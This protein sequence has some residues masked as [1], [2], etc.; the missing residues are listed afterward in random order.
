MRKAVKDEIL[1]DDAEEVLPGPETTPTPPTG[2][3]VMVLEFILRRLASPM[4][5]FLWGLLF[6]YGVQLHNLTPNTVLDTSILHHYFV[7]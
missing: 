5:D 7:S 4:H 6:A 3:Q 2:F 1:K